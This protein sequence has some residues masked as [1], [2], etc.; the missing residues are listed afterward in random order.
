MHLWHP[1]EVALG[2][3]VSLAG[4]DQGPGVL[5]IRLMKS[6]MTGISEQLDLSL[7][8]MCSMSATALWESVAADIKLK[9]NFK[10]PKLVKFDLTN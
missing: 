4:L 7:N 9:T 5:W 3:V 8:R 2:S 6:L 10:A 1:Q